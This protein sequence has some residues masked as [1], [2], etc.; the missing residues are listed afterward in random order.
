MTNRY[1]SRQTDPVRELVGR[2]GQHIDALVAARQ[3]ET[4]RT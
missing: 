3:H 1:V 2:L 4:P